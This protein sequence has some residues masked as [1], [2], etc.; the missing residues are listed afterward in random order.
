MD[1]NQKAELTHIMKNA[2]CLAMDKKDFSVV[3]L[4]DYSRQNQLFFDQ[5]YESCFVIKLSQLNL[6]EATG[7]LNHH[8]S[9]G[10]N[11]KITSEFFSSYAKE[12]LNNFLIETRKQYDK[13]MAHKVLADN[14]ALV[15]EKKLF[16]E[17]DFFEQKIFEF[18]DDI[19][20]KKLKQTSTANFEN[21]LQTELKPKKES[22]HKVKI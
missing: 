17:N 12:G 6:I 1:E 3:S 7:F 11:K 13:L 2:I 8:E 19:T 10:L 21:Y 5:F 9:Y 15:L 14:F 4:V 16:F 18:V 20:I 22:Y